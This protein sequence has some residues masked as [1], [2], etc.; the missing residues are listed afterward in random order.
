MAS[1]HTESENSESRSSGPIT[2]PR[3]GDRNSTAAIVTPVG[4]QVDGNGDLPRRVAPA[5]NDPMIRAGGD[6]N[7]A[8]RDPPGFL[9]RRG[10]PRAGETA[11][12]SVAFGSL[13]A[14]APG[15]KEALRPTAGASPIPQAGFDRPR[16]MLPGFPHPVVSGEAAA[17]PP[18]VFTPQV[19][20]PVPP[21]SGMT[22]DPI[23][24]AGAVAGG[25]HPN[26]FTSGSS[27]L[28]DVPHAA[29]A[30]PGLLDSPLAAAQHSL[31]P[32]AEGAHGAIGKA[33]A[34]ADFAGHV[35]PTA[36]LAQLAG[37]SIP[38]RAAGGLVSGPG[39]S[40]SD[41]IL[42]WLSDGEFV[43]N[44]ATTARL[45][46]M[47]V[48]MNSGWDPGAAGGGQSPAFL[49]GSTWGPSGTARTTPSP[50]LKTLELP[51]PVLDDYAEA[52]SWE[53]LDMAGV[54]EGGLS[55]AIA[56]GLQDGLFGAIKGG[57]TGA[58]ASAGSQVGAAI[59]TAL[60]A[61]L[62]PAAPIATA[63]GGVIGS[64]VGQLAADT[65]FKPVE[66]VGQYAADTAKEVIGSG[67]G[68]VDL[69]KGQGGRTVRQDIYNFNGMDPKSAS[70]AVE[71]VRRRRTLAQQRGGGFGR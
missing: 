68:L 13:G 66:V 11:R 27:R 29:A 71:R 17:E 1:G 5:G 65:V 45:L 62:G 36:L 34:P 56:G 60:G 6:S 9:S 8:H 44:A 63:V 69:A 25:H 19:S 58:A 26:V 64:T 2:H 35:Q 50:N 22:G 67:F 10:F 47:L 59:G 38:R 40:T 39:T 61:G 55:S 43:V 46:P 4:A 41:D 31:M 28:S 33:F 3:Y 48:A 37:P 12:S 18:D 15:G 16:S 57:V 51:G 14:S 32:S 53:S 7:D 21:A 54:V 52:S 42:T 30:M 20:T 70:I 24:L 49:S 23:G